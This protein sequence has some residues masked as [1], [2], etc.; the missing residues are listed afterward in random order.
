ML[1]ITITVPSSIPVSRVT[2]YRAPDSHM[3]ISSPGTDLRT[4][5]WTTDIT[6]DVEESRLPALAC[7]LG[8]V[9]AMS[10]VRLP[11]S[12]GKRYNVRI[13]GGGSLAGRVVATHT[14]QMD[15]AL[16]ATARNRNLGESDDYTYVVEE[17]Q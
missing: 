9:F 11:D 14:Y 12:D 10:S 2:A 13:S 4:A 1:R 8:P 7:S 17:V 16:D 6:I 5:D 3:A 15:A